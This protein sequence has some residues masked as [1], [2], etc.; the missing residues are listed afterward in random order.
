MC[1]VAVTDVPALMDTR[2]GFHQGVTFLVNDVFPQK[3]L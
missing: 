3:I 1:N 2:A